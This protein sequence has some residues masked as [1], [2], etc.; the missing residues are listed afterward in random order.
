MHKK[1]THHYKSPIK[2]SIKFPFRA[3]RRIWMYYWNFIPIL[4]WIFLG[5]Y[6]MD[7]INSKHEL[8]KWK[9]DWKRGFL[10]ALA[11]AAWSVV[12]YV[13][14]YLD[15]GWIPALY[16]SFNLPV[17]LAA[18]ALS[19]DVTD[20]Y[21]IIGSTKLIL[22]NFK[23]FLLLWWRVIVTILFYIVCTI[24]IVTAIVTI[25]AAYFTNWYLIARFLEEAR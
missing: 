23:L 1:R 5:K 2:E 19:D 22:R 18:Y 15:Y 4:G 20:A 8:P 6:T 13:L 9:I 16:I 14:G 24:P 11:S 12:I 10:F 17:M 7:V 21:N 3:M 25:P